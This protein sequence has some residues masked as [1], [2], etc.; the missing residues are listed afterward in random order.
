M[1]SMFEHS[2]LVVRAKQHNHSAIAALVLV[3]QTNITIEIDNSP[4]IAKSITIDFIDSMR[5]R[6]ASRDIYF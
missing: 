4:T 6:Q 3:D 1:V 2:T 5:G